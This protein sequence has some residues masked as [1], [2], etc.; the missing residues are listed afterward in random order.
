MEKKVNRKNNC[1]CYSKKSKH[2]DSS[3]SISLT[4]KLKK[5]KKS[6]KSKKIKKKKC[7]HSCKCEKFY[8][9][10]L[11]V[12]STCNYN[13]EQITYNTWFTPGHVQKN[14]CDCLTDH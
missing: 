4:I 9:M 6:K 13:S 12:K 2:N 7:K 10:P 14:S 5:P 11:P 8:Y 3:M 1:K